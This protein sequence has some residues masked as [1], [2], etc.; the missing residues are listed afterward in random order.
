MLCHGAI[1]LLQTSALRL[2]TITQSRLNDISLAFRKVHIVL[3]IGTCKKAGSEGHDISSLAH[4][5]SGP[6]CWS[7]LGHSVRI[8]FLCCTHAM[9][10]GVE[11]CTVDVEFGDRL[12]WARTPF[13]ND[14]RPVCSV[15]DINLAVFQSEKQS[16]WNF[17]EIA[18]ARSGGPLKAQL[19]QQVEKALDENP[20]R[21]IGFQAQYSPEAQW[22]Y[23]VQ[24]VKQTAVSRFQAPSKDVE[25][26]RTAALKKQALLSRAAF[27]AGFNRIEKISIGKIVF[28]GNS[29]LIVRDGDS[30]RLAA[31]A[32]HIVARLAT[33]SRK[34][35]AACRLALCGRQLV[36]LARISE[37]WKSGQ[38]NCMWQSARQLAG[39]NIGP[40][41]KRFDIVASSNPSLADWTSFVKTSG[42]SGGYDATVDEHWQS[43][44]DAF[45]EL[46]VSILLG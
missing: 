28:A 3:L 8:D 33:V 9:L 13:R 44:D 11:S 7:S 42:T 38:M 22:K 16:R 1:V 21:P 37:A 5:N 20:V 30:L 36:L 2:S 24:H 31:Q 35:K 29:A 4:Q 32:W 41:Q 25:S 23:L 6:T 46:Q 34:H 17:D 39:R 12:Q 45:V 40:K 10:T 27:F 18:L 19:I 15:L 43:F 14:H 26:T